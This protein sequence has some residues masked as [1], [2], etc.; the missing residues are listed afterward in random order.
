MVGIVPLRSLY[1]LESSSQSGPTTAIAPDDAR[2]TTTGTEIEN[3]FVSSLE[4]CESSRGPSTL[5]STSPRSSITNWQ[6][7]VR[8]LHTRSR[9]GPKRRIYEVSPEIYEHLGRTAVSAARAGTKSDQVDAATRTTVRHISIPRREQQRLFLPGRSYIIYPPLTGRPAQS[10]CR[11]RRMDLSQ[12][13]TTQGL[14]KEEAC[15]SPS[16]PCDCTCV[17]RKISYSSQIDYHDGSDCHCTAMNH[18]IIGAR[19]VARAIKCKSNDLHP[20]RA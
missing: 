5:P 4:H 6:L 2:P 13:G 16:A 18:E 1:A 15:A 12:L 10:Y 9:G 14:F 19:C 20:G 3:R 11:L 17:H 7:P 8:A